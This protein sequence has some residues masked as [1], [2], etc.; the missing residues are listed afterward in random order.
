MMSNSSLEGRGFATSADIVVAS[1]MLTLNSFGAF[2]NMATLLVVFRVRTF[3]NS[4]GAFCALR[5]IAEALLGLIHGVVVA[6]LV[7]VQP[8]GVT[9]YHFVISVNRFVA[10]YFPLKFEEVFTLRATVILV[11]SIV[12]IATIMQLP[13][14]LESCAIPAYNVKFYRTEMTECA[15]TSCEDQLVS[16]LIIAVSTYILSALFA[17]VDVFVLLK[18]IVWILKHRISKRNSNLR[19]DL[20]FFLQALTQDVFLVW[21]MVISVICTATV[22]PLLAFFETQ[23]VFMLSALYNGVSMFVF[24]PEARAVLLCRYTVR[25]VSVVKEL[26]KSSKTSSTKM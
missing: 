17:V 5:S 16:E 4:F 20:R 12:L 9:S 1:T 8:S 6:P 21:M 22:D 3:H 11:V 23:F 7:F 25:R 10:I 24:N 15:D 2:F 19:R 13:Y 26:T 14:P 18:V